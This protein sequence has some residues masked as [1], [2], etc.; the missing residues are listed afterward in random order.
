[1]NRRNAFPLFC[2]IALAV[3]CGGRAPFWSAFVQ[4]GP[5]TFNLG[6]GVAS[7]TGLPIGWPC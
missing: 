7:S 3:G 1:M 6:T 5:L 4:S 2:F